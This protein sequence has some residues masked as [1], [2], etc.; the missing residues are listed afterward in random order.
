M[1]HLISEIRGCND[2]LETNLHLLPKRELI[3]SVGATPQVV[4]S[5]NLLRDDSPHAEARELKALLRETNVELH[6]GVYPILDMQQ[7]S[8]NAS[9]DAGFLEDE[10]AIAVL[11]EVCSVYNDGEREK[12]EA[13]L[14]AGTLALGREPCPSYSGWGGCFF[15]ATGWASSE[16][17]VVKRISQEHAIVTWE[18]KDSPCELDKWLKCTQIMLVSLVPFMGGIL[19]SI[20]IKT[21]RPL[22]LWMFGFGRGDAV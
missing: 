12:P 1:G 6:A 5:Q 11:T 2:A 8:T 15:L 13:L 7:F 3:I 9:A 18:S 19:L 17:L 16:R 22:G 20:R 21:L 14:A 10:I 4:S